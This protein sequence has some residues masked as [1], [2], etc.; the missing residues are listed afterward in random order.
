MRSRQIWMLNAVLA[1]CALAVGWRLA[2]EWKRG[3]ERYA[4][5]AESSGE[6]GAVAVPPDAARRRRGVNQQIVAKNLFSPDRSNEM[7]R[8]ERAESAGPLPVV[9]GTMMLGNEYEALMAEAGQA[10]S[11]R[12]RR[13]KTGEQLGGYTVVEIQDEAVIVEHEGQK[14][15]VNVYQ[16]ANSVRRNEGRAAPAGGNAPAPVVETV[17][18]AAPAAGTSA[19]AGAAQQSSASAPVVPSAPPGTDPFLTITVEGNRRRYERQ[20]PFGPQVWYEEIQ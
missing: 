10:E 9:F 19:P 8:P 14:T 7:E 17:G 13:V 18:Q 15:T 20:T 5:L 6:R 12:F 3:N 1:L 2:A 4:R 11:G 16:S